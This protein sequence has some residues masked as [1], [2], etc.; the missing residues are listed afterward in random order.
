MDKA[1]E[2]CDTNSDA[3]DSTRS[4]ILF[5]RCSKHSGSKADTVARHVSKSYKAETKHAC[6]QENGATS[7]CRLSIDILEV[8]EVTATARNTL[9]DT[10]DD[11]AR[12]VEAILNVYVN[13]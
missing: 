11:I 7:V 4:R 8:V 13:T 6:A 1:S 9:L 12:N 5:S 10:I 2:N 3:S